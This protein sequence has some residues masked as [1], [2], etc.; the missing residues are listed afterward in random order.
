MSQYSG[1]EMEDLPEDEGMDD[2][3]LGLEEALQ[4]TFTTTITTDEK[5]DEGR[6]SSFCCCILS[7]PNNI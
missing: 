1:V 2:L 4:G 5:V 7:L 3:D 6:E